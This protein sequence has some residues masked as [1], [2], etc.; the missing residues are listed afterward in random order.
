MV[1]IQNSFRYLSEQCNQNGNSILKRWKKMTL[2]QR[3]AFLVKIDPKIY[4]HQW[5]NPRFDYEHSL[6]IRD[7]FNSGVDWKSLDLTRGRVR[8]PYRDPCLLPYL[9]LEALSANPLRLLGLLYNRVQYSPEQWAPYDSFLLNDQWLLGSLE[10]TYNGQCVVMHGPDYGKLKKWKAD[11]A[12]SWST[13][14]FPRGI[15]IL[16]AQEKLLKFL[17]KSIVLLLNGL[18]RE[19]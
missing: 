12:H 15:L 1:S 10:L 9:N 16:E 4:P 8:R 7:I 2:G 11:E 17:R 5:C 13:I 19:N 14:G 18:V 6:E 3:R